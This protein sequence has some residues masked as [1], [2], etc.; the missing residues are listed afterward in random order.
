MKKLLIATMLLL[1][2]MA[3]AA[4]GHDNPLGDAQGAVSSIGSLVATLLVVVIVSI[5]TL[6]V[7]FG[8]MVYQGQKKKAEHQR[9]DAGLKAASLALVATVLGTAASYYIVGSVGMATD[10]NAKDLRAGNAVFLKPLLGTGVQNISGTTLG[11]QGKPAD[12]NNNY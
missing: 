9:E 2:I 7:I 3:L 11:E 1:P 10:T 6:P 5:W 4:T 8:F 12:G